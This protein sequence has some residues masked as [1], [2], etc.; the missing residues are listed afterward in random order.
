[1]VRGVVRVVTGLARG[2]LSV[3]GLA[4]AV[5][6]SFE[7]LL[8]GGVYRLPAPASVAK[9]ACCRSIGPA[10]RVLAVLSPKTAGAFMVR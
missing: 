4:E 6:A 1:L 8:F 5:F 2:A 3:Q 9:A 10:Y 7:S